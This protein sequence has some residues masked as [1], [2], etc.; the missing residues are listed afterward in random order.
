MDI[1]KSIRLAVDT[2]KV[3]MGFKGTVKAVV[4]REARLVVVSRNARREHRE[5]ME[6]LARLSSVPLHK[7][8]GTSMELG[9]ICGRP[10]L[11]SFLGVVEGGDSD[12]FELGRRKK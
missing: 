2:G 3:C 9:A 7:F 6:R 8:E 5:D 4:N 11:V 1:K 10:H 12:I